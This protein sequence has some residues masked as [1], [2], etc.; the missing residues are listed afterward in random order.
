MGLP[1]NFPSAGVVCFW[2]TVY[3]T[4]S[5]LTESYVRSCALIR[6]L[7]RMGLKHAQM[8]ISV[9]G[10][11][12]EFF[13]V[14]VVFFEV[15]LSP[16]TAVPKDSFSAYSFIRLSDLHEKCLHVGNLV[17]VCQDRGVLSPKGL[18]DFFTKPFLNL[19]KVGNAQDH[20][21]HLVV[22]RVRTCHRV[23]ERTKTPF[24]LRKFLLNS[25]CKASSSK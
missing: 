25:S 1:F 4:D 2:H 14:Q 15:T 22:G 21:L 7:V 18:N 17:D 13:V 16:I 10:S 6:H 11:N 23:G 3:G 20:P 12:P 5:E 8:K 19:R 24:I 9:E